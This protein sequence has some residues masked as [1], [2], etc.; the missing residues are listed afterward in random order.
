MKAKYV[1]AIAS[2]LTLVLTGCKD[3]GGDKITP[4]DKHFYITKMQVGDTV[5]EYKYENEWY[6]FYKYY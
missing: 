6:H 2:S 1:L 5:T 4:K 3:K